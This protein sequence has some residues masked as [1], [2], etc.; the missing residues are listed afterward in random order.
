MARAGLIIVCMLAVSLGVSI[1]LSWVFLIA[2]GLCILVRCLSGREPRT[3]IGFWVALSKAPLTIPLLIYCLVLFISGYINAFGDGGATASSALKEGLA[4]LASARGFLIYLAVFAYFHITSDKDKR[5][6]VSTF[7]YL[8]A[9]SGVFACIQQVFNFHPFT[10]PYLQAT[11]FLNA[12]MPYAGLTQIATFISLAF[13][14]DCQKHAAEYCLPWGLRSRGLLLAVTVCNIL[15]LLFASERSAW[16]GAI[17]ASL[18]Y[19]ATRSIKQFGMAVL[20]GAVALVLA[21]QCVPVVK[22]RLEPLISG[23][24]DV[25]VNDR[26]KIWQVAMQKFEQK[27]LL[28]QGPRRFPRLDLPE[29]IVPG[30][31]TDINHG[32]SNYMHILAT[33]GL[34]G[35]TA[36]LYLLAQSLYLAFRSWRDGPR[37]LQS[38]LGQGMLFALVSL[39]VAGIFEYN[40]GSAQV[41]LIQWFWLAML[42]KPS[43]APS[44]QE[45]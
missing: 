45:K 44:S 13:W 43:S 22:T 20:S 21:Y 16:L 29:S 41:R 8:G 19:F 9:I 42:I 11:G 27:P 39:A 1:T 6:V 36:Y 37:D 32:H 38:T 2:L 12:P 33:T 34:I 28:G 40:F 30:H 25:G 7:L 24:K 18:I 3:L 5:Y 26:L 4:A 35:I 31:S 15:G 17:I 10:Y 23:Q 14:F